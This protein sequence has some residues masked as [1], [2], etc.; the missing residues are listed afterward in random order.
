MQQFIRLVLLTTKASL[1]RALSFLV[2]PSQ[3]QDSRPGKGHTDRWRYK[4]APHRNTTL[5]SAHRARGSSSD[6]PAWR[7]SHIWSMQMQSRTNWLAAI[8]AASAL[9]GCAQSAVAKSFASDAPQAISDT[10]PSAATGSYSGGGWSCSVTAWQ[11]PRGPVPLP[12]GGAPT[13]D[14]VCTSPAGVPYFGNI[15]SADGYNCPQRGWSGYLLSYVQPWGPR[16]ELS[17]VG[18]DASGPGT[19]YVEVRMYPAS[20]PVPLTL[21]RTV[22][23]AS[24]SPYSCGAVAAEWRKR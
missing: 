22:A 11:V 14:Y 3:H 9:V 7:V 18:Y 5:A 24:P 20:L 12:F 21:T 10:I 16:G 1:A 2:P 19:L 17:L 23:T 6:P 4:R 8:A 13:V 15:A